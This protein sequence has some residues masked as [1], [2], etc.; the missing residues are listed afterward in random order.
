MAQY[1]QTSLFN[2]VAAV[3]YILWK[4]RLP[5]NT[6]PWKRPVVGCWLFFKTTKNLIFCESLKNMQKVSGWVILQN[7][8]TFAVFFSA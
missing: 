6:N 7:M 1:P 8:F 5:H 4:Y 2:A 3:S